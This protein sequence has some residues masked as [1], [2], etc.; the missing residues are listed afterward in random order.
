MSKALVAPRSHRCGP[1]VTVVRLAL[2]V[3]LAPV[4]HTALAAPPAAA[5]DAG[6]VAT[7][8]YTGNEGPVGNSQPLCLCIY[9]DAN[10]QD[11]LYCLISYTNGVSFQIDGLAQANYF[12]LAFIDPNFDEMVNPTEPFGIYRN[13]TAPPADQVAAAPNATAIAMTFGDEGLTPTPAPSV[14]PTD[15]PPPTDTPTPTDTPSPTATPSATLTPT[16]RPCVGDCDGSGGVT[17]NDL[18]VLVNIALG[19][20]PV[21]ACLAGD[22]NGDGTIE[23]TEIL[24][25][26]NH[27]L[28]GCGPELSGA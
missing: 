24:V 26:V 15:T 19:N 1:L 27:A 23:I 13:R 7:V 22:T 17:V 3:A 11:R 20:T 16:P 14:T 18:V 28:L 6:I 12:L 9:T 10:L 8:T 4:I 2:T 21:D 25:A 5:I